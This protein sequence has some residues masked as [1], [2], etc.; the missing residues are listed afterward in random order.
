[1]L[2]RNPF[3]ALG[4]IIVAFICS[5]HAWAAPGDIL[6][7]FSIN[8]ISGDGRNPTTPQGIAYR[9]GYLWVTDFGTDRIYRV[10]PEDVLA[11]DGVTVLFSAGDSD[12]NIPLADNEGYTGD[13]CAAQTDNNG[14]AIGICGGGGL[15]FARNFLW[16]VSTVTDDIIKIDPDDGNNMED[17]NALASLVFPAPTDIAYDGT[18]FWILDWQQNNITRV[19]PEDGTELG[20]IPGP[21]SL[22]SYASNPNVINARP[23]GLTYDGQALWVADRADN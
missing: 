21:S 22:P 20:T 13:R 3:A 18:H 6:A 16:N 7:E 11:E 4:I 15:T 9:N 2:K 5:F 17:Q 1:M 8:N 23:F 14:T 12:F 19:H 10:Y